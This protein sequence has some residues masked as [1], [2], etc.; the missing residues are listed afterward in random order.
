MKWSFEQVSSIWKFL[1]VGGG[2]R[3]KHMLFVVVF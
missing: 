3:R 1:A 2:I